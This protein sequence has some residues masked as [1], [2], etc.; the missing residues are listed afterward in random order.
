MHVLRLVVS[1]NSCLLFCIKTS[2]HELVSK[3][4]RIHSKLRLYIDHP[5]LELYS[6][7]TVT[8][9]SCGIVNNQV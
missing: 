6:S 9:D 1:M 4:S 3:G 2:I 5:A 7:C 8:A